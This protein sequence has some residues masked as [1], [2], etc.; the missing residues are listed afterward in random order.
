MYKLLYEN[1]VA[2]GVIK[3]NN[4]GSFTSFIFNS[5]NTDYQEYLAW[6]AEGNE[7]T[8]ADSE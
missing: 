4:N 7:P 6:I 1:N 8:P 2:Y 3:D 5:E